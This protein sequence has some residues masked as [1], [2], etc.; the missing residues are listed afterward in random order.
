[1]FRFACDKKLRA[2]VMDFA[3][4]SRHDNPWAALDFPPEAGHLR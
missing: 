4:D 1:V 2:A 3:G